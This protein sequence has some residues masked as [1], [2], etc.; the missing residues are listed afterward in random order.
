M[1][2]PRSFTGVSRHAAACAAALLA[3]GGLAA[4]SGAVSGAWAQAPA[5]AE[6]PPADLPPPHMRPKFSDLDVNKDG[7]ISQAEFDAFRPEREPGGHDGHHDGAGDRLPP[8]DRA[9]LDAN[10]DGKISLDEFLAPAKA[11]F[12]RLDANHDGVLEPDELPK[13]PLQGD[14]PPPPPSGTANK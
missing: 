11:H 8:P 5:G 14:G 12:A 3:F 1:P 4:V 10:K 13:P 2:N 7:V 9:D 6:P